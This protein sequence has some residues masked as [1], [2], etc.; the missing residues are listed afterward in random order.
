MPLF[1]FSSSSSG[2]HVGA[3]TGLVVGGEVGAGAGAGVVVGGGVAV[4]GS[5]LV[6]HHWF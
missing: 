1:S 6:G 2:T 5:S 4:V 3:G